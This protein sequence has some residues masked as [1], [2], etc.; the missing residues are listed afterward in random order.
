MDVI[1]PDG[2][3]VKALS[4]S[5][6]RI[7]D[8]DRDYG[9]YLDGA[10]EPTWEA[11]IIDWPDRGL[12]ADN[13]AAAAKIRHAFQRAQAGERVELGCIG[14]FGRT[15]TTLACMALLASVA[16]D[17]AVGW[18]R[19]HYL[20][21]AIETP[22]QEEW[23]LWFHDHLNRVAW[24]F[25]RNLVHAVYRE[26][27]HVG[28]AGD[29]AAKLV[30]DDSRYAAAAAKCK[31]NRSLLD[32]K[33]PYSQ[34]G[35]ARTPEDVLCPY[36]RLTALTPEDLVEVYESSGWKPKYG[37]KKWAMI[38]RSLIALRDALLK[39]DV[40]AAGKLCDNLASLCHNSGRLVPTRA[41][42]EQSPYIRRKWPELCS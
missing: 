1:F 32:S 31:S 22:D 41:E 34:T 30:I 26:A 21:G 7:N 6:R 27:R 5:Q 14:G 33:E 10:W 13:K 25:F 8:P 16:R 39:A 29:A 9:L 35:S 40:G 28:S 12:P 23:V 20:P 38:A 15:G 3:K 24:C 11:D 36:V 17:H 2:T 37:G 19:E 4:L 42:W 18:V